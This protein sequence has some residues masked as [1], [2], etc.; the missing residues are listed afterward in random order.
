MNDEADVVEPE[1]SEEG[2]EERADQV[3]EQ[4]LRDDTVTGDWFDIIY[5]ALI[6]RGTVLVV[7]PRGCGKTHMMRYTW[8]RCCEAKNLPLAIY[9]S[10]NRYL[11]LEPLLKTR[12]DALSL[13][14]IWVLSRILLAADDTVEQ[15]VQR[16]SPPVNK[17][18]AFASFGIDRGQVET[19]IRRLEKAGPLTQQEEAIANAIS[20]EGVVRSLTLLFKE[21]GRTRLVLFLDDAALVFAQEF[22]AEFLDVVRVL[23][24]QNISPKCSVYPGSTEYGPR[25]HA[26]HEAQFVHAWLPVD[27]PSYRDIMGSIASKRFAEGSRLGSDVNG[28]LMYAAFGV[29]RAYLT[30]S[31]AMV[32]TLR[33]TAT[34]GKAASGQSA[35][36]QALN[37]VI[38]EHR[39]GRLREFRSLKLKM[40]KFSTIIDAGE[41]L[42]Q[43]VVG[44]MKKR[45][46]A[47][48]D[49]PEKQLLFGI[50]TEEMTAI[51][52]RMF[53]L[54]V[55]A[56][57][58][59][60]LPEVSHGPKRTYHRYTPH[61][62]ALI[63]ARAFAGS[64]RGNSPSQ[65]LSF[66]ERKPTKHPIRQSLTSL[67]PSI[68][69]VRFDLPPCQA[70]KTPRISDEQKF[71]HNCGTRLADDSTFTRLMK[72]PIAEVPNLSDWARS[73]IDNIGIK[74]IAELLAYED[75]GT[76]LR[77]IY[78]VGPRRAERYL[79]VV[80]AY[81]DEFLS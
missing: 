23:K 42:F 4:V 29:P 3:S 10:F 17:P 16:I 44:T 33:E 26:D 59:F 27:H 21:L 70:C 68:D 6:A 40:P 71:C 11:R 51:P 1:E 55:E 65:T 32:T 7:G 66:I 50:T 24:Q 15:V 19:L 39:D 12:N 60:E 58:L 53:R 13:F 49:I 57:L 81:I 36:Q 34:P 76:E 74:T 79:S 46:D 31:R 72:L 8:L 75:P 41:Q 73:E 2:F 20:I 5:K 37:K 69:S 77:K 18:N 78:G 35:V 80:N 9:V 38:Q 56:G 52:R 61:L 45:N 62:A 28:V 30:M 63:A 64:S 43:S 54:L 14:Q 22:M 48:A 25:F 67:L 47:L